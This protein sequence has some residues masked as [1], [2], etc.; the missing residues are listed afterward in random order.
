MKHDHI[1]YHYAVLLHRDEHI[2]LFPWADKYDLDF[3]LLEGNDTYVFDKVFPDLS[4]GYALSAMC[5]QMAEI[6]S[7][8]DWLHK[9]IKV[10]QKHVPLAHLDL[11]PDN[12]LIETDTNSIVG[13]WVLTDF[14]I[15]ITQEKEGNGQSDLFSLGDFVNERL[16]RRTTSS[17]S[18]TTSHYVPE[19]WTMRVAPPRKF[20]TYQPPEVS[21]LISRSAGTSGRTMSRYVGRSGD[22]WSFGCI[23]AEV[24]AFSMGRRA[25][26]ESFGNARVENGNDDFWSLIGER[27]E[28]RRKVRD[29][30]LE[31]PKMFPNSDVTP[32]TAAKSIEAI[33][34]ILKVDSKDRPSA[35]AVNDKISRLAAFVKKETQAAMSRSIEPEGTG[36]MRE[37]YMQ[38]TRVSPTVP[39]L[40]NQENVVR[41]LH[42]PFDFESEEF[43]AV[44]DS[45][46]KT[47]GSTGRPVDR[48]ARAPHNKMPET[49]TTRD[50]DV[51]PPFSDRP[52]PT[53]KPPSPKEIATPQSILDFNGKLRSV[54][55][56]KL[57][58]KAS[59]ETVVS[60]VALCPSGRR[61]AVITNGQGDYTLKNYEISLE[62]RKIGHEVNSTAL[63]RKV[64]WKNVSICNNT[65]VAWGHS[66]QGYKQVCYSRDHMCK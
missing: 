62:S 8:L 22:I 11:K 15:S 2:I 49:I 28:P 30:L 42:P 6:A 50:P 23:L 54:A 31:S 38:P 19:K 4:R 44:F 48:P 37:P 27:P 33:D 5:T 3:F 64:E 24:F 17:K 32:D 35:S 21:H 40:V 25:A 36:Q 57:D 61:L 47:P 39:L 56:T 43:Y 51:N 53:Q 59:G 26:V 9:S 58:A 12:I 45:N 10:E 13:R 1:R 20:G 18:P 63:Q 65:L 14:G 60:A 66:P 34:F 46:L 52:E 29:W 16:T 7:A 55:T 41:P